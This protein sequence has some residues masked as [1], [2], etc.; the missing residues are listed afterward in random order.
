MLKRI[1]PVA[2]LFILLISC[3][4]KSAFSYNQ[5]IA[6]IERS[7]TPAIQTTENSVR[8]FYETQKFDSIV[9]VSG[10]MEKLVQQ[11]IDEIEG[12]KV[13]KAKEVDN[14][15]TACLSA[16]K[17]TKDIYTNYKK[18]G[19]AAT[20]EERQKVIEGLQKM[21]TEKSEAVTKMQDAQKKFAA[22]NGFKVQ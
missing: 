19:L 13:P 11:K 15:R 16:F 7:I 5:E 6:A 17:I 4:S 1:I 2:L 10:R 20:E 14:F 9:A 12:L 8:D 18:I 21:V 22:E 3:K